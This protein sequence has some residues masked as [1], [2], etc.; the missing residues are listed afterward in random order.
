LSRQPFNTQLQTIR[1][2]F[3]EMTSEFKENTITTAQ[4][5]SPCPRVSR[6]SVLVMLAI[7]VLFAAASVGQGVLN[8]IN[9]SQDLQWSPVS[10]LSTGVNPYKVA[11]EG[12]PNKA[13]IFYQ[14]PPYLHILY[15]VMLPLAFLTFR[16]AAACWAVA[17]IGA[18]FLTVFMIGDRF[19]LGRLQSVVLLLVFLCGTPFRN[20]L[21]NGQT[22][23]VLLL[24]LVISWNQ[25]DKARSGVPLAIASAKYSFVPALWLWLIMERKFGALVI[26]FATLAFGWLAFSALAHSSPAETFLQPFEVARKYSLDGGIGDIMTATR[27]FGLDLPG[28][29]GV[30]S[31][32]LAAIVVSVIAVFVLWNRSSVLEEQRIFAALC[33]VSLLAFRHLGYDYVLLAPAMAI[34]FSIQ[35]IARW[36][37]LGCVLYF[38]FLLKSQDMIGINTSGRWIVLASLAVNCVLF[39]L[40]VSPKN[41]HV[42]PSTSSSHPPARPIPASGTR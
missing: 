42:R 33:T 31:S 34:G 18:S 35:G 28:V 20:A 36:S 4:F 5:S 25:R 21:G 27:L 7:L 19:K 11:M 32:Y 8:A 6:S 15:I 41:A 39:Y 26:C 1:T 14:V 3:K 17:G 22:S 38:W 37:V 29:G 13:L 40:I 24:F 2:S 9:N 23:L 10:L 16:S 12:N 30:G